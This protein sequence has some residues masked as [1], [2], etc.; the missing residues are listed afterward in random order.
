MFVLKISHLAT[1]NGYVG[2]LCLII[3]KTKSWMDWGVDPGSFAF[4]L[5]SHHSSTE[6][7]GLPY[8]TQSGPFGLVYINTA[9][10]KSC[11]NADY[12]GDRILTR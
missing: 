11:K 10:I 3:L 9:Q 12:N 2:K 4:H 6:S 1:L 7:Q 5:F 8:P